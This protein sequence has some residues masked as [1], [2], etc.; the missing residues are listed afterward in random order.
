MEDEN[1]TIDYDELKTETNKA[2]LL[3]I[4]GEEIWFPKSQCDL[5][6]ESSCIEIPKWLA[7]AKGLL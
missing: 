2:W 6:E 5:D 4:E 3:D 1:R 7:K